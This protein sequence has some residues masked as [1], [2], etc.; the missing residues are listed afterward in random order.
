[1]NLEKFIKSIPQVNFR[2]W[3][4]Y[5]VLFFVKNTAREPSSLKR[6]S[7]CARHL[8]LLPHSRNNNFITALPAYP[9]PENATLPIAVEIDDPPS[10]ESKKPDSPSYELKDSNK[11]EYMI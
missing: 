5:Y 11:L 10:Y 4:A 7:F 9:Y 2:N 8:A 1:M 3:K 6:S